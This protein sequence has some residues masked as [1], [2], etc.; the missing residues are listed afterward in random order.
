MTEKNDIFETPQVHSA[1]FPI[2][3]MTCAA[4]QSRIERVLSRQNGIQ[5]VSVNL[6]NNTAVIQYEPIL[7]GLNEIVKTI[8]TIGYSASFPTIDSSIFLQRSTADNIQREEYLEFKR[9]S[10]LAF[11]LALVSMVLSMALM[12]NTHNSKDP[13][14][15]HLMNWLS[16]FHS[17]FTYLQD[18]FSAH[19]IHIML[20]VIHLY[21]MVFLG[22]DFYVKSWKA[23]KSL[24]ADM[25]VLVAIG[26]IAAFSYSF[27]ISIN[28]LLGNTH[29][30]EVYY[31]AVAFILA[32]ILTGK[33]LELKSKYFAGRAIR[34]LMNL[35]PS[36]VIV[37]RNEN[38]IE[39]ALE[40]VIPGDKIIVKSGER[41]PL[42]G[43]IILGETQI[44]ESMITGE[45]LPVEKVINDKVIGGTI[46]LTGYIEIRV[47]ADGNSGLL[48]HII[49]IMDS[50]IGQKTKIQNFADNVIAYF[51][52]II[53]LLSIITF[54]SWY[55]SNLNADFF[56]A[57][58]FSIAVLII[59]C[60]CAMGLAIP[61]AL[62][63][64]TGRASEI[65][66]LIRNGSVLQI[67]NSSNCFLFD[68]TGTITKGRLKVVK[69]NC[70]DGIDL[71]KYLY[72]ITSR[73]NHPVSKAIS[74]YYK[75]NLITEIPI[76][77]ISN[78]TGIGIQANLD[79]N[80][81]HLGNK[82]FMDQNGFQ[83]PSRLEDVGS[84]LT[85]VFVALNGRVVQ[86]IYFEDE[87]RENVNELIHFLKSKSIR[88][89][90]VSGDKDVVVQKVAN[91]LGFDNFHSEVLPQ[92]KKEIVQSYKTTTKHVVMIGDGI[93]DAPAL[94]IADIGIAM[95]EGSDIAKETG[96]VVLLKSDIKLIEKIMK[97]SKMTMS[98]THQNLFWAFL[99]NVVS[100]P[101]AAGV[102][103][104]SYDIRLS[105]I[106]ASAAMAF[107]SVSVVLNSLRLLRF[108]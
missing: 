99:Y 6:V 33:T 107:S 71:S 19:Y 95:G 11:L 72:T 22:R 20:I 13:L 46:N 67:M 38:L 59:A 60:P 80:E 96:D 79:N 41:I 44:D 23:V 42:D 104:T 85:S 51:V 5:S 37:R 75:D 78:S 54:C 94:A 25:N 106:I 31:E 39:I 43:V 9:K 56:D 87:I 76:D 30:N 12:M 52:P 101:I 58:S 2:Q 50:A 16:P 28:Y 17:I 93:N 74:E 34:K 18:I 102:F 65:G 103:Y 63:T 48:A 108:K 90:L 61:T 66:I 32:F 7:I 89:V 8:D 53:I 100:I 55:F 24:W 62:L 81:I 86:V 91:Q 10:I 97:L 83:I 105:P 88:T 47:T 69:V 98:I 26:T 3:G 21:M 84:S 45:S 57:L 1:I 4:C 35:Q 64:A 27:V 15:A 29:S 77:S 73:N 49:K 82:K 68:K 14:M 40:E 92:S 36:N 70:E